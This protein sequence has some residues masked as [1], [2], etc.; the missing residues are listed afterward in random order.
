MT[1]EGTQ[2]RDEYGSQVEIRP[3]VFP[4]DAR[5][6]FDLDDQFRWYA[7]PFEHGRRCEAELF[8][9]RIA[10]AGGLDGEPQP[11]V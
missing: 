9:Q 3:Q 4:W 6:P 8:G 1:A 2:A 5:H 7:V 10:R 11:L